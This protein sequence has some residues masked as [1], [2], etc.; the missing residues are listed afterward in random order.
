MLLQVRSLAHQLLQQQR[1]GRVHM[2]LLHR[3]LLLLPAAVVVVVVH[4]VR[5]VVVVCVD[6]QVLQLQ[7]MPG[8]Q[9]RGA[10]AS[11]WCTA[12]AGTAAVADIV[13]Y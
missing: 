12:V 6:V 2:P 1:P 9:Q 3:Q 5:V 8:D 4:V 7:L 11:G 10:T 13:V